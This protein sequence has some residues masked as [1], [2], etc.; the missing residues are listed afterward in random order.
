MPIYEYVCTQCKSEFELR[1]PFI[2]SNKAIACPKCK[3]PAEKLYSSFGC[4]TGGNLQAS[5]KPFRKSPGGL[6]GDHSTD[7][8][9][10]HYS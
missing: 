2:D 5:D 7:E 9:L 1:R 10:S 6:S 4:K 8:F 3:S